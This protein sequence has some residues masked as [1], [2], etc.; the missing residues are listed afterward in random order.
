MGA[1]RKGSQKNQRIPRAK[2]KNPS[3]NVK[4]MASCDGKIR[5]VK[6]DRERALAKYPVGAVKFY[7]CNYCDYYRIGRTPKGGKHGRR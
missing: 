1:T 7:N 4:K 2:R 5:Y 3:V 6:R